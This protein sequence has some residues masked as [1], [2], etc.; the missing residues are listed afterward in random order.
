MASYINIQG[1]PYWFKAGKGTYG[2]NETQITAEDLYYDNEKLESRWNDLIDRGVV[3]KTSGN[4]T[5]NQKIEGNLEVEE[6]KVTGGTSNDVLLGDGTFGVNREY[7]AGTNITIDN[8]NPNAP[9]INSTGGGGTTPSLTEV[10]DVSGIDETGKNF[11]AISQGTFEFD[12]STYAFITGS[13]VE[14]NAR[15]FQNEDERFKT[16]YAANKI[17]MTTENTE[18]GDYE[19]ILITNEDGIE[20]RNSK[21]FGT[22]PYTKLGDTLKVSDKDNLSDS[23]EVNKDGITLNGSDVQT[24]QSGKSGS[25]ALTSDIPNLIAG[26]NVT[27][28]QSGNNFTINSTG[29]SGS[30]NFLTSN[31]SMT[32]S[33]V[34]SGTIP[35]ILQCRSTSPLRLSSSTSLCFPSRNLL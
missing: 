32:S 21:S 2:L 29:G 22:E 35:N 17:D 6:L 33:E 34:L 15:N 13:R 9:V 26:S 8:T 11:I 14:L 10:L 25:V 30:S 16:E 12:E 28:N 19:E 27:I 7:Q 1:R 31:E 23:L 3:V 4:S 5:F 24:F 18:T 20:F